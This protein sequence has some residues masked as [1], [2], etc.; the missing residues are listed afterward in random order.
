MAPLTRGTDDGVGDTALPLCTIADRALTDDVG[1]TVLPLCTLAC[2]VGV[3]YRRDAVFVDEGATPDIGLADP[4]GVWY[5]VWW[6]TPG[7]DVPVILA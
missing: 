6:G 2:A 3:K 1:E 7:D 4:P 5:R